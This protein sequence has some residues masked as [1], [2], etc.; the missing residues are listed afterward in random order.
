MQKIIIAVDGSIFAER[1]IDKTVELAT[2]PLDWGIG[3]SPSPQP[4]HEEMTGSIQQS[5]VFSPRIDRFDQ[6]LTFQRNS[7]NLFPKKDSRR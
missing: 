4:L 1:A 2:N 6:E 5:R 7:E 3:Q